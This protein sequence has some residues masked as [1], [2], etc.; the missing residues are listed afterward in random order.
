LITRGGKPPR[1][2]KAGVKGPARAKAAAKP[3]GKKKR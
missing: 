2:I 1:V 3:A